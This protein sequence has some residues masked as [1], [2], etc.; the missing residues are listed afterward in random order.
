MASVKN[1][2][3]AG[4]QAVRRPRS[5]VTRRR[6]GEAGGGHAA[7]WPG[8]QAARQ[9]GGQAARQVS[10]PSQLEQAAQ[11]SQP[12][13]QAE[14]PPAKQ[15]KPANPGSDPQNLVHVYQKSFPK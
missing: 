8:G 12:S 3:R 11:A 15:A 10:Q 6:G 4:T 13:Q 7:K 1:S 14:K 9:P 5:A 2:G